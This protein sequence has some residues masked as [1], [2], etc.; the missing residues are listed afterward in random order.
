MTNNS[1]KGKRCGKDKKT[2]QKAEIQKYATLRNLFTSTVQ[3][4]VEVLD[5]Y[6]FWQL[7]SYPALTIPK[8]K[9]RAVLSC[10]LDRKTLPR[11]K[12]SGLSSRVMRV[13]HTCVCDQIWPTNRR[14]DGGVGSGFREL[15]FSAQYF[16]SRCCPCIPLHTGGSQHSPAFS[17]LKKW[18]HFPSCK[19]GSSR[20]LQANIE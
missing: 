15:W 10:G 12:H 7:N 11:K 5:L 18:T 16:T 14:A 6:H 9:E 8:G 13:T 4:T 19:T 17:T 20:P 1:E 3:G 2:M